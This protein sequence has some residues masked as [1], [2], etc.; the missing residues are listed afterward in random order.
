M[1]PLTP[2]RA[3]YLIV[4]REDNR[5]PEDRELLAQLVAQHR[6]L[7]IAI[8][9]ADEFL[10]LLRQQQADGFEA[11]LMKALKSSLKPFQTFAEGLFDD[12][13]AVKASMMLKVSNG[14]VEGSNN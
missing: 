13:A 5:N 7:A 12:Y 10:Q 11:W 4:K 9:L 2:R 6:E 1:P 14:L 3:A 8:E